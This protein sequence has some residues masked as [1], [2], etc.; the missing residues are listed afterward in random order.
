MIAILAHAMTSP[1]H[2]PMIFESLRGRGK[3]LAKWRKVL[4]A[5]EATQP[6][7]CWA[8]LPEPQLGRDVERARSWLAED[9]ARRDA[10]H[11]PRGLYFGLDLCHMTG[12]AG[13]NVD[14]RATR[15]CDPEL[16]DA[17]WVWNC[18]WQGRRHRI[19]SLLSFCEVTH[20]SRF[21]HARELASTAIPLAYAGIV[22]GEAIA[23]LD[24]ETTLFAVYGFHDGDLY[25]LARRR[26]G[27]H[28]MLASPLGA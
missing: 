25:A 21:E 1:P 14:M 24:V 16:D 12:P 18:E 19:E 28:E 11:P 13:F 17:L 26:P 6:S 23:A 9:L 7:S 5:M 4:V 27:D 15:G 10:P 8:M 20:E 3:P 2:L 22:L